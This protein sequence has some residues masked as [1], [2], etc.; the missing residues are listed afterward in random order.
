MRARALKHE[1]IILAAVPMFLETQNFK[2]CFMLG[3]LIC[4]AWGGTSF[5]FSMIQ[6]LFPKPLRE[7]ALV[8]WLATW[9]QAAWFVWALKPFWVM[10]L[11][12]LVFSQRTET[13]EV[14]FLWAEVFK[15]GLGF[16]ALLLSLGMIHEMLGRQLM[17]DAFRIPVGAFL[18]MA[19]G[20]FFLQRREV[21]TEDA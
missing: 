9:T 12:L 14:K 3:A 13:G 18:M 4:F 21:E 6:G 10:S 15:R 17:L 7:V 2:M 20:A 11:M 5:L 8:L 16:W 19:V 1:I